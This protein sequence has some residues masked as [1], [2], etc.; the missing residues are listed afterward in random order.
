MSLS[1]PHPVSYHPTLPLPRDPPCPAH[2]S[3]GLLLSVWESQPPPLSWDPA[4]GI[5]SW[6]LKGGER[7]KIARARTLCRGRCLLEILRVRLYVDL[8]VSEDEHLRS[9]EVVRG[10]RGTSLAVWTESPSLSLLLLAILW[11]GRGLDGRQRIPRTGIS[12]LG[13]QTT[14]RQLSCR[15]RSW[16]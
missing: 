14:R 2:L 6:T 10:V 12:A 8:D 9:G 16:G 4:G 1:L 7:H 15:L 11:E 5:R 3:L 13:D